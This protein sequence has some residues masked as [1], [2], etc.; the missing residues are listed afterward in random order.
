M[1]KRCIYFLLSDFIA[2]DFEKPFLRS[3]KKKD[4][5]AVQIIDQR[6]KDMP[7]L[8]LVLFE[9]LEN[10]TT[11]IIDVNEEDIAQFKLKQQDQSAK[12]DELVSKANAGYIHITTKGPFVDQMRAYFRARKKRLR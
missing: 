6:E 1:R 7:K 10:H 3:A 11:E 2:E 12:L 9:D 5:I 8:G 4:L